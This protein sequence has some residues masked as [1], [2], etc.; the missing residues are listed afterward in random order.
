M[1]TWYE[2]LEIASFATV[3]LLIYIC[4]SLVRVFV[5]DFLLNGWTNF[6][7]IFCAFE[8]IPGCFI[9][10]MDPV[11]WCCN[12]ILYNFLFFWRNLIFIFFQI[13]CVITP[14]FH[15]PPQRA[16]SQR[17]SSPTFVGTASIYRYILCSKQKP[18]YSPA[19]VEPAVDAELKDCH[20]KEQ[21]PQTIC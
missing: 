20:L 16:T 2:R 10:T 15:P 17:S 11:G 13:L 4:S 5:T 21:L 12:R 18:R 7:N 14:K 6:Y 9:F 8:W 3:T 19:I 1:L